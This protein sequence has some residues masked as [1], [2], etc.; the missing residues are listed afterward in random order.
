MASDDNFARDFVGP[1][2]LEHEVVRLSSSTFGRVWCG[3][4]IE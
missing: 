1:E 4:V 3:L 2:F